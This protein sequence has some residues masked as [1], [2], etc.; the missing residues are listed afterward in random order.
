DSAAGLVD[1]DA[2]RL[3]QVVSNLLG[4][5][6]KFTPA[7]GLVLVRLEQDA[8]TVRLRVSDSGPGIPPEFLPHVFERFSQADA[9]S[10]RAH[11]GLGL[12]LAIARHL[13]ELHGG[14]V[15]VESPGE[16][17]GTT[18]TVTLP[19]TA[20]ATAARDPLHAV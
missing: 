2:N 9:S 7:D 19:L 4:N 14:T 3:Q 8:S 18:F 1:G 11:G 15:G 20:G 5:A 12:G 10:A 17:D 16:T 6:I 13:T